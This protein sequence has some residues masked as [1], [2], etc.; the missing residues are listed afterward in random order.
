MRRKHLIG[1]VLLAMAIFFAAGYY[2]GVLFDNAEPKLPP[3]NGDEN[4]EPKEDEEPVPDIR[5]ATIANVGA[6]YPHRPQIVQA[7]LGDGKYD[8]SPSFEIIAPLIKAADLAVVTFETAQAG[9]GGGYT[10]YPTFN[11]PLELTKNLKDAGFDVFN[12]ANNHIM[13][14]GYEGLMKTIDH[15][16]SH[17]LT[18]IGTYKSWEERNTPHVLDVNGIKVG[19]VSYTYN[20]NGFYPPAGHEYAINHIP[21]FE[22]VQPVVEDII[23]TRQAGADL[24][25]VYM[26][27]GEEYNH[28]PSARQKEIAQE[29][30]KAGADLI[31]G[32]HPHVLQPLDLITV[33]KDDGSEHRAV[34]I[35]ALGNFCTNQHLTDGVPTD[36][37]RYGILATIELAKDM[38]SGEAWIAD[39]NY[40]INIC[41]I[42]WRHRV[43]PVSMI[44]SNPPEKYNHS[45]ARVETIKK[46]YD[47][48]VQI[49][50]RYNFSSRKEAFFSREEE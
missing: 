10:G 23:K 19:F 28:E 46:Q 1:L 31:I 39:V 2:L 27:W 13:D 5:T 16:R 8:F 7:H 50:E 6:I 38:N 11:A 3:D 4:R 24:V 18:V 29:L 32:T 43:I 42:D 35:N 25:A 21:N 26:H 15:I 20:T 12:T 49:L 40:E 36:L 9:P 33:E 44:L 34:V 14:R 22:T 17:G 48:L 47:T 41:H 30:A 45:A 37:T